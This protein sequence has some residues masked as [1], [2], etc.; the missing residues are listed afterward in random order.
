[1]GLLTGGLLLLPRIHPA[2]MPW[3]AFPG[4][5]LDEALPYTLITAKPT[6]CFV[7]LWSTGTACL[8]SRVWSWISDSMSPAPEGTSHL[9][10]G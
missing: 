2:L 5:E 1:M 8:A 6:A 9:W 10:N 7:R 3:K 4:S